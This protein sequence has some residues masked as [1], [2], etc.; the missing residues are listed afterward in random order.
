MV[1]EHI[2]EALLHASSWALKPGKVKGRN[3]SDG[4]DCGN[5]APINSPL[6]KKRAI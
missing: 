1:K 4:N 5:G 6:V 3:T 2:P